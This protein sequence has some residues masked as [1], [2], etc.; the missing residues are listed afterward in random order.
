MRLF[1]W[2][3]STGS[4]ERMCSVAATAPAFTTVI[5]AYIATMQTIVSSAQAVA[6]AMEDATGDA[7]DITSSE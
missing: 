2:T 7:W 5:L 3:W 6:A 4:K 1:V